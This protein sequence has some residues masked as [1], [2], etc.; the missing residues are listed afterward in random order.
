MPSSMINGMTASTAAVTVRPRP[1]NGCSVDALG[2]RRAS[3]NWLAEAER[4]RPL[5]AKHA[6]VAA[7]V[8]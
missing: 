5:V 1:A 7:S 4:L 8:I 2:G 3:R 6:D